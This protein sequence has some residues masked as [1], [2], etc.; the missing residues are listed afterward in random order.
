MKMPLPT[1]HRYKVC[2]ALFQHGSM[3]AKQTKAAMPDLTIHNVH[4]ALKG[5]AETGYVIRIGHTYMLTQQ[6]VEHFKALQEPKEVYVGQI[7]PAPTFTVNRPLKSLPWAAVADRLR[8][9]SYK[10][11][12]TDVKSLVGYQA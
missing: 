7:V 6:L 12:S 5:A 9:W 11:G 8:D 1:T 10:N 3:T 2:L 4:Q